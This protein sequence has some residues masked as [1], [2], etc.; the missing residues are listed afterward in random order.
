MT[1]MKALP[2]LLLA[3]AVA[4]SPV[5][6]SYADDDDNV[7]ASA[8][9][10]PKRQERGAAT[11]NGSSDPS[12]PGSP[13]VPSAPSADATGDRPLIQNSLIWF[14]KP[15]PNPPAP[16][17]EIYTFQ[18]LADLPGFS[19]PMFGWMEGFDFEACALGFSNTT[20]GMIGPYGTSTTQFSSQ[21]C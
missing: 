17:A 7:G 16:T 14:G 10:T 19:K 20:T 9:K 6:V 18:P 3:A 5:A 1:M 8:S 21:G 15:N 2:A 4:V 13:V 11:R 12:T